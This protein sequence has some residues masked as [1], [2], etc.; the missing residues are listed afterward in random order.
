MPLS[1]G[2]KLGPYEIVSPIGEGGMGEVYKAR[3]T[4]LERTV[5]IKV[6]PEHI[7]KREDLRARFEREARAVAS[8]NHPNICTLYDIGSQDGHGYMIMEYMEGETLAARIAKGAIPLDQALKYAAQIADALDRAHRAG[9]T[10]RDVKPPNIML[11]RDG[12]KVLDFGLAKATATLGSEEKTLVAGLTT[13]GTILGTP[14]YMA[15]EQFSGKEA[16]ARV[17]IWAFGAVLYEMVTG[18]KAFQGKDYQSLLGAILATDPPPMSVKPFTPAWLERMVR[19]CLTKDPEDRWQSMRDIVLELRTPPPETATA[20]LG[21]PS[22]TKPSRWMWIAAVAVALIA[23]LGAGA[24]WLSRSERVAPT[25]RFSIPRDSNSGDR[26]SVS[27][28][29]RTIAFTGAQGALIRK[30]WVRPLDAIEPRALDGTDGAIYPIWSPDGKWIAFL[31]N[32][33]PLVKIPAAGGIPSPITSTPVINGGGGSW[34]Q[35]GV[36]LFSAN[37]RIYRVH[38]SG[39]IPVLVEK[40]VQPIATSPIFLPDGNR[41]LYR[42]ADAIHVAAL[43]GSLSKK[44]VNHEGT[45]ALDRGFLFMQSRS[46]LR[47]QALDLD[48]LER[49]GEVLT[50]SSEASTNTFGAAGGTTAFFV[51]R[52]QHFLRL[53]DRNGKEISNFGPNDD[54]QFNHPE[55]TVDGSRILIDRS[56]P[57]YPMD[58]WSIDIKRKITSRLSF[59]GRSI[60][61]P[62]PDGSRI[63][64]MGKEAIQQLAADGTGKP[65]TILQTKDSHHMAV[66]PDGKLLLFEKGYQ[67]AQDIFLLPL[68]GKYEARPLLANSFSESDPQFSPD[69]KWIAYTSDESGR[70]EIYVQSFPL[71]SGKWRVSSEGGGTARWRGDSQEI[72]FSNQQGIYAASVAGKGNGL[73][74]SAPK[75]LFENN[76]FANRSLQRFAVTRDGQRFAILSN[77]PSNYAEIRVVLG[78]RPQSAAPVSSVD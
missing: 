69:G 8:L 31:S 36:I 71:G 28:D 18:Q 60:P 26:L 1:T 52:G 45:F 3:D 15:P 68:D 48:A 77:G 4:R 7:A 35:N 44:V 11:T 2:D 37:Q 50:I 30:I 9:V 58:S 24:K 66:S 40:G 54:S 51:A 27:P 38:S 42:T 20:G 16:D 13:E 64:V 73:D 34:H 62:S 61:V 76:K 56:G 65:L 19:R 14:Q 43:D 57:S 10:H 47:A 59:D 78:W 29:G 22:R 25:V 55:F 21:D 53:V 32:S 17:D 75:K 39:G 49:S 67:E 63:Y 72:F 6:L 5:A 33:A 70:S 74:F 41:F 23:G 12:V 46:A